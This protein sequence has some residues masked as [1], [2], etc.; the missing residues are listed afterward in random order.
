M[1]NPFLLFRLQFWLHILRV[2]AL[3]FVAGMVYVQIPEFFYDLKPR[4]PISITDPATLTIKNFPRSAFVSIDGKAD[5]ENAFVYKRY[6]LSYTYFNIKPYGMRLVVRT[7]QS[8][9]E[10]WKSITRFLGKLRPFARQPFYYKIRDIYNEKFGTKVPDDAFFLALD[11]VPRLS[12]WQIG[13]LVFACV[14]WL[15]MLYMFYFFRWGKKA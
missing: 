10:E 11:D 15:V 6:G 3:L 8:V 2:L 1:T 12:G 7:Y 13:A 5:F 14:L 4:K 9:T